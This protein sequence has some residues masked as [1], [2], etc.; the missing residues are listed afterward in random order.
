MGGTADDLGGGGLLELSVRA[1]R[2]A[3][4]RFTGA[5][6][7][8]WCVRVSTAHCECTNT[9][10]GA[11]CTER[12]RSRRRSCTGAHAVRSCTPAFVNS[13]KLVFRHGS[14]NQC[15]WPEFK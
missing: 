4:G 14:C 5:F 11:P 12:G 3:A 8:K 2:R 10:L 7:A 15:D 9:M 1:S 6:L 13:C